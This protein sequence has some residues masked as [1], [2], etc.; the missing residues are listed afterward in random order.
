MEGFSIS[1][2]MAIIKKNCD[3]MINLTNNLSLIYKVENLD[4]LFRVQRVDLDK[5]LKNGK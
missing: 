3:K 2:S 5:F 4:F 1:N